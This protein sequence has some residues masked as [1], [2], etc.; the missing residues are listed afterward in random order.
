[1]KKLA[2]S[3][4]I[5]LAFA[6]LIF[7]FSAQV[8][9]AGA[10][11]HGYFD[12]LVRR[13]DVWKSY[14]LRNPGQL[15][16]QREGGYAAGP[17]MRWVTYSPETD[18]DRHKQD[19]A[20]VIIPPFYETTLLGAAVNSTDTVLTL[21]EA[22]K[23]LYP[24]GRVMRVDR[25]VMTVTGWLDDKTI[26]VQRGT[27][28]STPS[29]HAAGATVAHATNS[30]RNTIRL[31]LGTEDGHSYFFTWDAYWT[32]S[33]VGAGKFN[34]KAFQ[35]SSGGRD[36]DTLFL[37]PDADYNDTKEPCWNQSTD[38]AGFHVRS[39]NKVGGQVN[40]ALTDGNFLGP[41]VKREQP[42]DRSG[43][44]CIKPNQWVRF[45]VQINQRSNDYDYV[46]M[47]VADETQEPVQVLSNV[48]IS[49][50]PSGLTPNS[51]AKFWL[52]FNSSVDDHF[53]I[54]NRDLVSYVRNFV[55]LRDN[56]DPR[57]LLVRPVPGAQAQPGP[58]PPRNVRIIQG[59]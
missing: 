13:A 3:T 56:N 44:F 11:E 25:E 28:A 41:L 46:D 42:L 5:L 29:S 9:A 1:M 38:I 57:S 7:D 47:W 33:Y 37:E 14:S 40:W 10:D 30:L 27:Y 55:A 6:L 36:G 43:D 52:E 35:F 22:Y 59:S 58:A 12:S 18:T 49:V 4:A 2:C 54:D 50:R 20:K 51:I 48:A 24:P 8:G 45:F 31:P 39:Y 26:S 17:D 23:P 16:T 32:D 15:R 34:H 21:D 19:A 53:R